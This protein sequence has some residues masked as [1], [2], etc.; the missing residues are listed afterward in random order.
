MIITILT[1]L[2]AVV[3]GVFIYRNN[4]SLIDKKADTVDKIW[5]KL[6]LTQKFDNIEKKL[7]ELKKSTN[8]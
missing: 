6:N 8:K 2:A 4:I 3:V 5:D 1:H 7:D